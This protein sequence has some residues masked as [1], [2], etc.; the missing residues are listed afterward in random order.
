MTT[1]SSDSVLSFSVAFRGT[2]HRLALLSSTPLS[3][4]EAQLQELTGVPPGLQKLIFKGK[5]AQH[6]GDAPIGEIGIKNNSKIQLLGTTAQ[7]LD[8]LKNVEDE[9]HRRE[10]IMRERA[11]KPQYKVQ[12]ARSSGRI[13]TLSSPSSS[14]SNFKFH[15]IVPLAHLPNPE[16]ARATLE[17]LASDPAIRHVM[18]KHEFT[19]GVLTELAPHEQ[20]HLLGLNVNAGQ[21]IKLRI[22]TDRYDGFRSYKEIRR[23]LCHELTHNVWGDHD[24]NFKELNS[25]L[26]RE[27]AEYERS[28][29]EGA[30]SLS[31]QARAAGYGTPSSE[32]EAEAQSNVLGGSASAVSMLEADSP[33]DR[34]QRILEATMNRL[35]KEEEEIEHSCGTGSSGTV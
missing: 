24:N 34:R 25:K 19:V 32:L 10:R 9:K 11:M 5:K 16:M 18:H 27:V 17:K 35:R 23:V 6:Q 31:G 26:N 2:T 3:E 20:P 21:E 30:H 14:N 7:E 4:L 12:P 29:I 8:G 33:E 1:N 15:S 28:A 22:Y 13:S